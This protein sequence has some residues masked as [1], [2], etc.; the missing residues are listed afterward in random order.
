MMF[1]P[2]KAD[3]FLAKLFVFSFRRQIMNRSRFRSCVGLLLA[4]G[5]DFTDTA[6]K[7]V[8]GWSIV[9]V[10]LCAT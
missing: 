10:S 1:Q 9:F 4:D 3:H 8:D 2:L 7:C 5:R 6:S